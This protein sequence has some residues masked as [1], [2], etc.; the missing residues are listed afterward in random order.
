LTIHFQQT[1]YRQVAIA[2]L[3]IPEPENLF[4]HL[5]REMREE[6][7]RLGAGVDGVGAKVDGLGADLRSDLHSLRADVASDLLSL[8]K[9]V[10][11]QFVT[12]R[13]SVTEYHSTTIGHGM[14]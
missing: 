2:I 4:L 7:R 12:L 5:L 9:R 11:D 8:D 14:L 13:R 6:S 3:S 10:N 1:F